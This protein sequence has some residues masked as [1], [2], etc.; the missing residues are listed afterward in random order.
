MRYLLLLFVGCNVAVPRHD[1]S[2]LDRIAQVLAEDMLEVRGPEA[3]GADLDAYKA[4]LA[5]LRQDGVPQEK[6]EPWIGYQTTCEKL[7]PD[8]M[9]LHREVTPETYEQSKRIIQGT[10]E[11]LMI[12]LATIR[13]DIEPPGVSPEIT[14]AVLSGTAPESVPSKP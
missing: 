1:W 7:L 11:R 13:G 6:L 10:G 14:A 5:R 9:L 3:F 2:K 4:E 12:Q 8:V